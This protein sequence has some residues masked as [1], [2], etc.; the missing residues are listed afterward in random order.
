MPTDEVLV[1]KLRSVDTLAASAIALHEVS[2]LDLCR[3]ERTAVEGTHRGETW[4]SMSVSACVRAKHII[5]VI[6]TRF[7]VLA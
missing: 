6:R 3:A 1:C 5:E 2:S 4:G 7:H